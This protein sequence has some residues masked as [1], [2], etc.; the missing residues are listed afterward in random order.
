M[1]DNNDKTFEQE[2]RDR[3]ALTGIAQET[4][5]E[6]KKTEAEQEKTKEKIISEY[7]CNKLCRVCPFPGAKCCKHKGA[8]H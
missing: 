1:K 5:E 4:K 3:K 7:E 6:Q 8:W 2:A